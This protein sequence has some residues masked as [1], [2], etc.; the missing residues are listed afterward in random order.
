VRRAALLGLLSLAASGARVK[1]WSTLVAD[2]DQL[3]LG[4]TSVK[5]TSWPSVDLGTRPVR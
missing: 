2:T 5:G 4:G 3:G 1:C